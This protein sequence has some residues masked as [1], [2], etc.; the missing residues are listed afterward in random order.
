[1]APKNTLDQI[2]EEEKKAEGIIQKTEN[3]INKEIEREK[4]QEGEKL[5]FVK[6]SLDK[7]IKEINAETDREIDKIGK[8]V[9][10]ETEKELEKIRRIPAEKKQKATDR[11]IQ[12]L[13]NNKLEI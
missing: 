4:T 13:F 6:K 11:V 9:K 2:R 5:S 3:L 1:M 12:K 7:E 8:S 10:E